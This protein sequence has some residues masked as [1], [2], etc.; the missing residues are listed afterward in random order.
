MAVKQKIRIVLPVFAAALILLNMDASAQNRPPLDYDFSSATA[1]IN[2]WVD[3]GYYPGAA[4]IVAKDNRIIYEKYFASYQPGTVAYIASAGKWL[5]A[6]TIAAVVDDGRLSWDDK[7]KKWLPEFTDVKGEATLRRLLSHTAGYPD[8]QPAGRHPDDY[9]FL[10]ESV[11]HIVDLPAD[12]LPGT[13]F[14]YGG[15]AMQVAGR[16]AELA[17][18]KIWETLFHDK[19]ARPLQMNNTHFTPVDPTPGHNPMLGG[20][21]R[22]S[23]RD[24]ARFLQM[25]SDDGVFEGRRILSE[26]SIHAMQADQVLSARVN[27][28][29][30]VAH[31]RGRSG[32]DI[33][34]LGEWREEVDEKGNATMISSPG[35]AGAYPWIDKTNHVYGFFLA[36]VNVEKANAHGFSAFYASPVL[37]MLVRKAISAGEAASLKGV[38]ATGEAARLG[39]A[40]PVKA[41]GFDPQDIRLLDGPFK[42]NMVRDQ[43]WLLS[44]E[45]NRLLHSF[46]VNAGIRSDARALGGWEALDME[47]RGHSTGHIL[48]ALAHMYASTGDTIFKNKADSLVLVLAEVQKVLNQ[49]GYLSAFPQYFIDRC[50]AGQ[51]V[52]APWYTLHKIMA[53]LLDM[54]E[55]AGNRQALQIAEGMAAWAYKKL[56]LLKP[57]QITVMLRNEFG[58]MNEAFYNLYA[59]TGKK[60]HLRLAELFYHRSSMEPLAMGEDKLNGV[61]ANTTIPKVIGEAR[62]YELTGNKKD[63]AIAAFFWQTVIDHHTYATGGN[64]D[65]EHFNKPDSLAGHLTE[66]TSESCNTYNMLKLTRHLFCWTA[67]VK[68]ADYYE[69]ALYNHILGSQDPETGMFCYFMPAKA[70]VFKLYSTHDH[71]FWCCMGTGSENHAK[72]GE[73]IYFHDDKG[74]YVNLF[75]PSELH[76]KE[77]GITLRQETAYPEE[78]TTHLTIRSD[79]AIRM[80]LYI[81]YPSWATSG[82]SVKVNGRKMRVKQVPGSYIILDRIWKKGDRIEITYPMSLRLIATPDNPAVAAIAYGPI[83]LAAPEGTEGMRAPEPYADTTHP[84]AYYTY[85]YHIPDDI[86]HTIDTHGGKVTDWLTPVKGEPLTFTTGNTPGGKAITLIPFYKVHHQRYVVYWELKGRAAGNAAT[87]Q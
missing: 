70:G 54:Y 59:I 10:R 49:D 76:W 62:G 4:F 24:Y 72:Y 20:G 6:A 58:G 16:M 1:K 21:A 60:E 53:G 48:S 77:K 74:I 39:E 23:L 68:Y 19:I 37:P 13:L 71:S 81:R 52:W 84:Y 78:A 29:E 44:L 75:I 30:Y 34:G 33:Y 14:H 31:A 22:T 26:K 79:S 46:R 25:I 86:I 80:P 36:R 38:T 43:R 55:Y 41:Y 8:Y 67:G 56:N 65:K 15:L 73:S 50:I 35:W 2:E 42:D 40:I 3:S 7:V 28:G 11:A 45:N 61:H 5:A 66:Y 64:S 51:Y 69:Q 17:S 32:T 87:K 47:L 9:Q 27:A 63:S 83:V 82:A 57:E 18:G 85:D 12:T